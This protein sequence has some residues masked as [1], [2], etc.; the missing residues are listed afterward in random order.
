MSKRAITA[1]LIRQDEDHGE[2]DREF[3]QEA[4]YEARFAAM[5]QMVAEADLFRGK[6]ASES[7]LQRTV[8]HLQR[9]E[10]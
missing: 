5:W 3:W 6:N 2:F 8:E 10:R 4:G 1:R 7:R 9:R